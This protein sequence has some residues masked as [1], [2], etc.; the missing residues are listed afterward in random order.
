M[1]YNFLKKYY[2]IY[3]GTSDSPNCES[4]YSFTYYFKEISLSLLNLLFN[5]KIFFTK[6]F[7]FHEKAAYFKLI[8]LTIYDIINLFFSFLNIFIHFQVHF[9]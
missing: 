7:L 6:N 9:F 1:K 3:I 4:I 2:F 8:L 5:K